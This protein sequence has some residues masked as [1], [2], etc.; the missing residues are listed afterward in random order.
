MTSRSLTS[1]ICVVQ[2]R[3]GST[4]L[5]GKVLRDVAGRPMLEY[6]LE[7]IREL[8]VAN[9]IVAT[10]T[11]RADDAVAV[12]AEEAGVD[13]VRGSELDVLD[14]YR[15]ALDAFPTRTVVRLTA[16]CPLMD[17]ELVVEVLELHDREKADYSSNVFPR[18]FPKGLDV[19]VISA[20][21]L[22]VAAREATDAAEREHVTPFLYRHPERFATANLLCRDALGAE[23]WTVDTAE[24]LAFV[25]E[26][27]EGF[28]GV[29][30]FSWRE[31][32][33]HVGRRRLSPAGEVSLRPAVWADADLLMSWRN[34]PATVE[35][36]R[37]RRLVDRSEHERWLSGVLTDGA[38]RLW[39]AQLDTLPIGSVR[40]DVADATGEISLV[41]APEWRARGFGSRIMS[42]LMEDLRGDL[43][44]R[45]LRAVAR[46][47]NLASRRL[48]AS[49]GFR[50]VA[51]VGGYCHFEFWPQP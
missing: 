36:S 23:R 30:S 19:E 13:V 1:T 35:S 15:A 42:T 49:C 8:P 33:E 38:R 43:Q 45:S 41:V 12:L 39:V 46:L 22:R 5:P 44:A 17:P 25:R 27:A 9:T 16:D 6:M 20:E 10:S 31:V 37:T 26:V 11:S 47:D 28:R 3:T 2:A 51:Q 29:T 18:S 34:D 50:E 7:R 32:L 14:R 24:D 21:A 40:L 4:R 48:F